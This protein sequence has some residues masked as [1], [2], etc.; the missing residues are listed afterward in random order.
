MTTT[1]TSRLQ[2]TVG[3]VL[4]HWPRETLLRFYAELADSP[5]DT[6]TIGET[7]F[8]RRRELRLDVWLALGRSSIC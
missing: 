6:V 8:A 1:D 3:P 5:A 7:V 2:L 4:Y